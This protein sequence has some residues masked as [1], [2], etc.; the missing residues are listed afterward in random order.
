MSGRSLRHLPDACTHRCRFLAGQGIARQ[1]QAIIAGLRESV[2][3]FRSE[4]RQRGG[5]WLPGTLCKG[6][7]QAQAAG[8]QPVHHRPWPH[9]HGRTLLATPSSRSLANCP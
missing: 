7:V 9:H 1:R 4:V 3:D 2:Q 6:G 5:A 8:W